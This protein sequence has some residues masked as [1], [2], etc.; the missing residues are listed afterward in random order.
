MRRVTQD[1]AATRAAQRLVRRGSHHLGM[2]NRRGV[3]T[4]CDK[5]ADVGNVGDQDRADLFG[6]LGKA[7]KVDGARNRRAA[8]EQD[9]GPVLAGQLGDFV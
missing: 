9:L 4:S 8:A 7:G 5:S 6:N 3:R 1:H 2:T